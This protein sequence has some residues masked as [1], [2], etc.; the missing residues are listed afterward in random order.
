[1]YNYILLVGLAMF[2]I[3]SVAYAE[4]FGRVNGDYFRT[5]D[6]LSVTSHSNDIMTFDIVGENFEKGYTMDPRGGTVTYGMPFPSEMP[7][8][9]Y[10][11]TFNSINY[12]STQKIGYGVPLPAFTLHAEKTIHTLNEYAFFWGQVIGIEPTDYSFNGNVLVQI[13]DSSGELLEDNWRAS[14]DTARTAQDVKAT[15]SEFRAQINNGKTFLVTQNDANIFGDQGSKSIRPILENGYRIFI[16]IDP[17]IY[18]AGEQYTLKVTHDGMVKSVNFRI[19]ERDI[20]P[21]FNVTIDTEICEYEQSIYDTLENKRD[22]YIIIGDP[23]LTEKVTLQM[24]NFKFTEGC[25]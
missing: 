16:K 13:L 7:K 9:V 24:N 19:I 5:G 14:H 21:I 11:I 25:N 15:K 12:T 8:G 2:S 18:T 6:F 10:D 1:M 20:L 17:I 23:T 4:D 22:N 3:F